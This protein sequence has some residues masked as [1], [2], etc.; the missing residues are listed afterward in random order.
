MDCSKSNKDKII[1]SIYESELCKLYDISG[2]NWVICDKYA[3]ISRIKSTCE[4]WNNKIEDVNKISELLKLSP[5][6][7]RKYLHKGTELGLCNYDGRLIMAKSMF[8]RK[9]NKRC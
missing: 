1:Q 8:K 9:E 7:I 4:L 3:S 5:A 2:V 6:T